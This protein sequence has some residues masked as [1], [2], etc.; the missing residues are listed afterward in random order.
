MTKSKKNILILSTSFT[1]ILSVAACGYVKVM[2]GKSSEHFSWSPTEGYRAGLTDPEA[3]VACK[4]SLKDT[5]ITFATG[6]TASAV[7]TNFTIPTSVSDC[8]ITWTSDTTAAIA[9][10]GGAATVTRQ[11]GTTDTAVVLT[12]TISRGGA[13]DTKAFPITVA[14]Q[15]PDAEAVATCV[16]NLSASPFT[17]GTGDSLTNINGN[18]TGPT[19]Q[20]DCKITWNKSA[21]LAWIT[22]SGGNFTVVPQQSSSNETGTLTATISRNIAAGAS[23]SSKTFDATVYRIRTDAERANDC[24]T[25]FNASAITYSNSETSSA[26]KSNFTLPSTFQGCTVTTWASNN[27]AIAVSGTT[28][29]VTRQLSSG[30]DVAVTLNASVAYNGAAATNGSASATVTVTKYTDLEKAN[31]CVTAFNASAITF[32]NSET[33][34]AVKSNFTLPNTFQ[35]C[36]LATFSSNNAALSVSGTAATVN[37]PPSSGANAAVTLTTSVSY[38]GIAAT[39]G[40]ASAALTVAKYTEAESVAADKAAL[41]ITYGG[42]DIATSVT[43]DIALL[44]TSGAKGSTITWTSNNTFHIPNGSSGTVNRGHGTDTNVTLTATITSGSTSDTKTFDLTVKTWG[45]LNA[46]L[47]TT[48]IGI[49][50]VNL[51]SISGTNRTDPDGHHSASLRYK[52]C[53]QIQS[54]TNLDSITNMDAISTTLTCSTDAANPAILAT[55][56]PACCTATSIASSLYFQVPAA[57]ETWDSRI[58]AYVNGDPNEDHHKILYN[59]SGGVNP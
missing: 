11:Y 1:T 46:N 10:S 37:R 8:E 35:S 7:T 42:S 53:L 56:T 23:D 51:I 41:T 2:N 28:A 5:S 58:Y 12:A 31:S 3:V 39:N 26:I 4:S 19:T 57:V 47:I 24:V 33:S 43:T 16:A 38:N 29:T 48:G 32:S 18:F 40:S 59:K 55:S 49:A 50:D 44:P 21:G 6:D 34:S 27:G 17:F 22:I 30:S 14:R 13:S 15:V 20:N 54:G 25:A 9:L 36:T 45:A 52:I